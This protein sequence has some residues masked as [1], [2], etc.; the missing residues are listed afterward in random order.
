[1]TCAAALLDRVVATVNDEV[2]TWS[3]LMNVIAVEGK[4]YLGEA[5]GKERDEKI[6]EIERSFLDNL[7]ESKLQIQEARKMGLDVSNS[8]IDGAVDEIKERYGLTGESLVTSL[9]AEGM[10]LR[11]YRER[12]S[13]QILLQKVI[14]YAVRNNIV[15]ADKEIE[16]YYQ[17]NRDKYHE[18]ERIRIRQIFFAGPEDES[19]KADI[20]AVAKELTGRIDKGEEFSKLASE[21][22]E[23]PSRQFGGDLGYI[24]RGLKTGEVS[25]PFWSP[26]GLHIIKVED[27]IEGGG[28]GKVRDTIKGNLFQKAFQAGYYD[29]KSGLREKAYIRIK[30]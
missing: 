14:N 15:I 3:E 19:Q 12:L 25:S 2:I 8:E 27:K 4:E 18:K 6:K 10:T 17:A 28:I 16:E 23:D 22:S 26:A 7:I 13:E 9:K 20:E 5:T 11:D 29:W 1:M 30:L 21:F 24:S